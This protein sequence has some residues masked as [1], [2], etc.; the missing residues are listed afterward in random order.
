MR[1]DDEIVDSWWHANHAYHA[2]DIKAAEHMYR[3]LRAEHGIELFYAVQLGLPTKFVHP[4]STVL[5]RATYASHLVVYQQ[6]CVGSDVDG[7][8]PTFKGPCVL[9]PGSKIIG[10]VTVGSNVWVSPGTMIQALPGKLVTIPDNTVV[11]NWDGSGVKPTK[12]DVVGRFFSA[13]LGP[14]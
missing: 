9:F 8:R 11:F 10:D 13:R 12:R 7:G 2:G 4:I 5:G 3:R 6:V 1:L 14:P